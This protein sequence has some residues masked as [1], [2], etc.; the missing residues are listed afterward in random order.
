MSNLEC[1]WS[2]NYLLSFKH[3][4]DESLKDYFTQ[5]NKEWLAMED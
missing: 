5:F 3:K 1:M 2:A 4:E